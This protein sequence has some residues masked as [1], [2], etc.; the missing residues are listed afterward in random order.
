MV[1]IVVSLDTF[2]SRL[3]KYHG[4]FDQVVL[5]IFILPVCSVS[6]GSFVLGVQLL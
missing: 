5:P 2:I 4:V 1:L 3:L 6:C